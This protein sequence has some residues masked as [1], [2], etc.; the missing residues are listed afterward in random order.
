MA[1]GNRNSIARF[2]GL[3]AEIEGRAA[4]IDPALTTVEEAFAS[5]ADELID[6]PY[7]LWLRGKL[8]YERAGQENCASRTS[9]LQA[10]EKNFRDSIAL[11]DRM[12]AQSYALRAATSLA[13]LLNSSSHRADAQQM[14]GPS[15]A[16][17]VEGFDTRDLIEARA[18]ASGVS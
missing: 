15:L 6:R 8:L 3:T 13:Q 10:A 12:G 18:V 5:S 17:F 2:L 7:L 4:S 14:L 11:A 16:Q 1:A 9:D